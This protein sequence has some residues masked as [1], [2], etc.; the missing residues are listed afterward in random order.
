MDIMEQMQI[1]TGGIRIQHTMHLDASTEGSINS[2]TAEEVKEL[3]E[4]MCRN[5]YNMSKRKR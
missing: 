1:F 5:E 4:Q 2:K 3:I